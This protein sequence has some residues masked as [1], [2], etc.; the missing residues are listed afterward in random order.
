MKIRNIFIIVF[1][2]SLLSCS[3]AINKSKPSVATSAPTENTN[4]NVP[5]DTQDVDP[6]KHLFSLFSGSGCDK[7]RSQATWENITLY[8]LTYKCI[9]PGWELFFDNDDVKS[10][11]KNISEKLGDEIKSGKDI[12]PSIGDTLRALYSV[13]SNN[14]KAVI[15]GQDPAP[16]KG[17]ATGLSFSLK[18]GIPANEVPS[19]QSVML[20]A[21]NEGYAMNL[22][23]GDLS[24]W[25]QN[26]VLLLNT[27]LTIPCPKDEKSC[28][29]AGHLK[30]WA[31]FTKLLIKEIDNQ[32]NPMAFVLWGSKAISFSTEINNS[33]HKVLKGGHPSPLA[34]ANKFFC[35]SYF[36]CTNKWLESQNSESVTWDVVGG[37]KFDT[38]CIWTKG[39]TPKCQ[40]ACAL[41]ACN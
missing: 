15:L 36:V 1:L 3:P 20:E 5:K 27:A 21:M 8:E 25:A 39:K 29:I 19:V 7:L 26:G 35:K 12:N 2:A 17:Q 23:S 22:N 14:V 4:Q 38:P 10:E 13:P 37:E 32:P 6:D 40:S 31:P 24:S 18:P 33:K 11:V 34:P 30:L 9:P 16:T 28:E 41:A